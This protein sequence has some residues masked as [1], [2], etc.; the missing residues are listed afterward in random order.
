MNDNDEE[1]LDLSEVNMEEAN[2]LSK[3]AKKAGIGSNSPV[4]KYR[5]HYPSAT[6][7][8]MDEDVLT[9]VRQFP[10]TFHHS[11]AK[12]GVDIIYHLK[13]MNP[14]NFLKYRDTLLL[15]AF[16]EATRYKDVY[17]HI[18]AGFDVKL[19][20]KSKKTNFGFTDNPD[21]VV[22]FS[23]HMREIGQLETMVYGPGYETPTPISLAEKAD[24]IVDIL[25]RYDDKVSKQRPFR[26]LRMVIWCR[27]RVM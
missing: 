5:G 18:G 3:R 4:L 14:K 25:R 15:A 24:Q 19:I 22:T 23:A 12:G 7:Y 13:G 21:N 26:V 2:H 16:Q 8:L 20:K 6:Q 9:S 1:I 10:R 27:T 17:T 11:W